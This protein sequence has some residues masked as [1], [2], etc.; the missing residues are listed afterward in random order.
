MAKATTNMSV[1]LTLDNEEASV[2][3]AALIYMMNTTTHNVKLRHIREVL[4]AAGV[5]DDG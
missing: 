5:K 1:V 2:V 4:E 3:L